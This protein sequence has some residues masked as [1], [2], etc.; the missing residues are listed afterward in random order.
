M[1]KLESA[2]KF[3][4]FDDNTFNYKLVHLFRNQPLIHNWGIIRRRQFIASTDDEIFNYKFEPFIDQNQLKRGLIFTSLTLQRRYKLNMDNLEAE[5]L[6]FNINPL[7]YSI[8]MYAPYSMTMILLTLNI[9]ATDDVILY[10]KLANTDLVDWIKRF[11]LELYLF[12]KTK[13]DNR[14]LG[15]LL[16]ALWLFKEVLND[17]TK[18]I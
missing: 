12:L 9:I 8:E 18:W 6:S 5:Q 3:F 13:K 7:Y 11:V 2:Q 4:Y 10:F 17:D 15:E 16:R 14:E 1:S